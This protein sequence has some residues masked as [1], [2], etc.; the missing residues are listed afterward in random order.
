MYNNVDRI[1]QVPVE[2]IVEVPE[3]EHI[4]KMVEKKVPQIEYV[5]KIV[6]VPEVHCVEKIV[7][8]KVPEVESMSKRLSRFLR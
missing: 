1:V 5:E 2:K 6:E 7:E 8:K 3:V 4:E